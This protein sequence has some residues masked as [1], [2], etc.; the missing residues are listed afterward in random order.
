MNARSRRTSEAIL[1]T[2]RR[3]IEERGFESVTMALVAEEVG[4]SRRAIYLHYAS[5]TELL[6][7]VFNRLGDEGDLPGSVQ[8]VWDAPDAERALEE[9]ALHLSRFHI[10]VLTVSRAIERARHADEVA[11]QL[12]QAIMTNWRM[13][14]G[15]LVRLLAREHRLAPP[16]TVSTA[17]DMVCA[18]M[19]F[20]LTE[21]LVV[22]RK[23]SRKRYAEHVTALLKATFLGDPDVV[24]QTR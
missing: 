12:W 22:A 21:H 20:E 1:A 10:D 9:W 18:L 19:S 5:R 8:P 3:L 7:A 23:W 15:R 6:V 4:V 24:T 17:T 2:T 14:A 11:E 13:H 16:W